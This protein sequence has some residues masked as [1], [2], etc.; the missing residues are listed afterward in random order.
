MGKLYVHFPFNL[1]SR[2]V[3]IM[4]SLMRETSRKLCCLYS[5][6]GLLLA[7]S[8]GE[9]QHSNGIGNLS[10]WE[11]KMVSQGNN[12]PHFKTME[13]SIQ[14]LPILL[15]YGH[16]VDDIQARMGWSD[17]AITS[18][19]ALLITNGF[20][21]AKEDTLIPSLMIL[22]E[23]GAEKI[24]S[25]LSPL[26]KQIVETILHYKDSIVKKAN[27]ISCFKS[28]NADELSLLIFS[29]ILLDNGQLKNIEKE[30]LKL[31]RPERNNNHYYASY[32]EKTNSS[33]EALGIY[34]NHV[35]PDSG[36]AL[37]RYGNQRYISEVLE[38][39]A[40]VLKKYKDLQ[41]GELFEY[42]IVTPECNIEIQAL[43][44]YFKPYLIDILNK[45]D[46]H[47]RKGF[48]N[49]AYSKEI[50]YEEYFMWVYHVLYSHVTDILVDSENIVIP[51]ER[52]SFYVFQP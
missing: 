52:V 41:E 8:C 11:F 26:A 29:N 15:H 7:L 40:Q 48:Q 14:Y 44:N 27:A 19:I 31:G 17:E 50:S 20:L 23:Q 13:D 34:G 24:R 2:N 12:R 37:C 1:A 49:S 35:Q 10:K 5:V 21:K 46:S 16:S 25:D 47:L 28:F 22:S 4:F 45:H 43:A 39:N 51:A 33:F 30:Y 9:T 3:A 18:K 36:F 32:Q 6:C 42:P 38:I